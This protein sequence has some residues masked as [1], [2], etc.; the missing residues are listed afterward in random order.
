MDKKRKIGR[1]IFGVRVMSEP[2]VR[3]RQAF[4]SINL[5]QESVHNSERDPSAATPSRLIPRACDDGT[6][7]SM[8]KE[9]IEALLNM[10]MKG[11]NKFDFKVCIPVW[12][13]SECAH[14]RM[15]AH[16][17]I[18]YVCICTTCTYCS[19]APSGISNLVDCLVS[20]DLM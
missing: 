16:K 1:D 20:L 17:N 13:E 5:R 8:T 9:D 12:I 15:H 4:S 2:R 11:K 18:M 6:P 10:K 7:T 3:V 14:P 19:G